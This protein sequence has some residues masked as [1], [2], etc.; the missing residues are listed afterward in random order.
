MAAHLHVKYLL[1]FFASHTE[2][3]PDYDDL[4]H[5]SETEDFSGVTRTKLP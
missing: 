4:A 1:V 3:Q 2:T 5:D